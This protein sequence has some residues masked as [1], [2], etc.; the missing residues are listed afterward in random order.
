M[1]KRKR[2]SIQKFR[3]QCSN[4]VVLNQK[5]VKKENTFWKLFLNDLRIKKDH[6][7][8]KNDNKNI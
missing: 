7:E 1:L 2:K 4:T 3:A 6:N 5:I 8:N